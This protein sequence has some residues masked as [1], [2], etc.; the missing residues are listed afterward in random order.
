VRSD[1]AKQRRRREADNI[2]HLHVEEGGEGTRKKMK[3][4]IK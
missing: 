2:L 3:T 4:K 1:V